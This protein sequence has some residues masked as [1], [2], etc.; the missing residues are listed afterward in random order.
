MRSK[1]IPME[2]N[3]FS[4]CSQNVSVRNG[5][6]CSLWPADAHHVC[7]TQL[8]NP[9]LPARS[10]RQDLRTRLRH[11]PHHYHCLQ[12]QRRRLQHHP[13]QFHPRQHLLAHT[14][15][16]KE[17]QATLETGCV[18]MKT[19]TRNASLMVV[20][21]AKSLA[22]TAHSSSAV[23]RGTIVTIPTHVLV[24]TSSIDEATEHAHCTR[25]R[26]RFGAARPFW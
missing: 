17:L 26:R 15:V 11:Y 24:S 12:Q 22:W 19:T 8:C 3:L 6:E 9:R 7:C 5:P 13:P 2:A 1:I 20:T 21:A 16:A 25:A 4:I 23:I 14:L 10:S 18:T